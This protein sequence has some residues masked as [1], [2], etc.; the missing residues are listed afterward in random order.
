MICEDEIMATIP[1]IL[2]TFTS[3]VRGQDVSP[4]FMRGDALSLLEQ[5][6]SESI[7]FCMTSPPY[8]NKRQYHN[9][10]MYGILFQRTHKNAVNILPLIQKTCVRY[11]FLPP[12]R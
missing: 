6:P 10:A 1:G 7:D 12:A 9:R 2:D 8:W 4:L 11:L 3:Y 5:L